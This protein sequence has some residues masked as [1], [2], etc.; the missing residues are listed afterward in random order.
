MQSTSKEIYKIT[1]ARTGRDEQ[2]Y[3]DIGNFIQKE[4]VKH[5]K[6]PKTLIIKL[7]GIGFWFLRKTRMEKALSFFPKEYEDEGFVEFEAS[8]PFLNV[9]NKRE[10][11]NVLKNRL[12]DYER[13]LEVKQQVK[14]KKNEFT[15]QVS[16]ETSE[17]KPEE[18]SSSSS[19]LV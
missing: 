4:T 6:R 10:I 18:H 19:G 8:R 14:T 11:Y 3:K 2:L 15:E 5:L 16:R 9:E 12:K 13:Y 7:K 17:N 1:A